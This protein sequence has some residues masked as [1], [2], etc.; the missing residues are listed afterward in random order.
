[1]RSSIGLGL[2]CQ[3]SGCGAALPFGVSRDCDVAISR[4]FADEQCFGL[5]GPRAVAKLFSTSRDPFHPA[6]GQS[7]IP[8]LSLPCLS[9]LANKSC[10]A[11]CAPAT[12]FEHSRRL[13]LDINR[14]QHPSLQ[15]RHRPPHPPL[16]RQHNLSP[17]PVWIHW[18]FELPIFERT[19]RQKRSIQRTPLACIPAMRFF[20]ALPNS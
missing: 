3:Q 12:A 10:A 17:S 19:R 1:M 7:T 15:H 13:Q 20:I 4:D 8:R 2:D 18:K 11:Y 16:R 6:G 9:S 5:S 14:L